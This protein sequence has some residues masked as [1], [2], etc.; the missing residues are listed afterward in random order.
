METE[1]IE[2]HRNFFAKLI[3]ANAGVSPESAFGRQLI[4]AFAATPR[5]LFVGAPPWKAFTR[6]GYI[7]THSADPAFLYQDVVVALGVDAPLNNGQPTLHAYCLA[8]LA[9]NKGER[10]VH[11][12]SGS[13][14]YT[15]VLARLVG[16]TGAVE[17]YEIHPELVRRAIE[18]LAEFPQVTV[19]AR[20]GAEGA[21]PDC[22]VLYVNAGASE[23]L[24]VWLD[25]LRPRGRL[26]FPL[27][28][29]T[30]MGAMLLV[31]RQEDGGFAARFLCQAQFVA[32]VGGQDEAAAPELAQTFANGQ[33]SRVK[34]LRR[35]DTPDES[36][37]YSG[38]GW[39]L[40]YEEAPRG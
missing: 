39:W 11:V 31:T 37:W 19:H 24:A 25:A 20:S 22:D 32:C 4:A 6:G 30:G 5:E 9:P 15:A 8:A 12:G 7:E 17:A 18:N 21:L 36:C 13:G 29:G 28:P 38:H 40:S 1:R 33:W 26:L 35:N 23:P 27:A 10:I 3:T 14:Y 34:S 16:E 2:A